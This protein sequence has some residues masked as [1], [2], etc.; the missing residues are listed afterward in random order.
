MKL[1]EETKRNIPFILLK[2]GIISNSDGPLG[3]S[4]FELGHIETYLTLVVNNS[5]SF[6][7]LPYDEGSIFT[8]LVNNPDDLDLD[9]LN[10]N[11]FKVF[12]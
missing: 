12:F 7:D 10:R 4:I 5:K 3:V 6:S 9:S 1:K 8:R 2:H 11:L